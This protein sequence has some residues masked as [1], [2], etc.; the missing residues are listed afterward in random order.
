MTWT[1][2]GDDG[3][4]MFTTLTGAQTGS[5]AGAPSGQGPADGSAL[6]MAECGTLRLPPTKSMSLPGPVVPDNTS[7]PGKPRAGVPWLGAAGNGPAGLASTRAGPTCWKRK[8]AS[9][10]PPDAHTLLPLPGATPSQRFPTRVGVGTSVEAS[11]RSIPSSKMPLD[12]VYAALPSGATARPVG[13]RWV[14]TW[15]DRKSVV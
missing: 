9:D 5:F 12:T 7:C 10:G 11:M 14:N 4:E 3:L 8:T 2:A 1:T 6:W 13:E 15:V